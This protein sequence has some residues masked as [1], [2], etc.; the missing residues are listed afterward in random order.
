M[1]RCM[2]FLFG[3]VCLLGVKMSSA[4]HNQLLPSDGPSQQQIL[5]DIQR[6]YAVASQRLLPG[7]WTLALFGRDGWCEGVF[8]RQGHEMYRRPVT[9]LIFPEANQMYQA[10][11]PRKNL[12]P[13][14]IRCMKNFIVQH[15]CLSAIVTIVSMCAAVSYFRPQWIAYMCRKYMPRPI[16]KLIRKLVVLPWVNRSVASHLRVITTGV[17]V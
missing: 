13:S 17:R 10:N 15:K 2:L 8:D 11:R 16:E 1:N 5:A 12:W 6:S 3:A 4:Q 9:I 14:R 7:Q